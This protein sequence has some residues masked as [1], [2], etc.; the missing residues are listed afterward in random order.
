MYPD[1]R[2]VRSRGI[3]AF[4]LNYWGA[5]LGGIERRERDGQAIGYHFRYDPADISR[6]A[7]FRDGTWVG[8][9]YA[10]ELQLADGTYQHVSLAEWKMAKQ[11]V[12][13]GADGTEGKTPAELVLVSDTASLG[14]QRTK[15]KKAAQRRATNQEPST[16]N[17]PK[18]EQASRPREVLDDETER[19]LRFLYG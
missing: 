3:P 15:E 16:P 10:K 2:T 8:D 18:Q 19:V 5:S 12:A 1:T 9:G 17:E 7:L 14:K 6:I 11:Q 13:R 4:G